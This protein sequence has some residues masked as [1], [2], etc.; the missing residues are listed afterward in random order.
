M[1]DDIFSLDQLS[2]MKFNICSRIDAYLEQAAEFLR[3]INAFNS[4]E[5][6]VPAPGSES[7]SAALVYLHHR[8]ADV[9]KE[10]SV[11]NEDL[12]RLEQIIQEKSLLTPPKRRIP[13]ASDEEF[14]TRVK[15]QYAYQR[16][17]TTLEIL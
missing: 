2:D 14:L 5:E 6:R 12:L 9:M 3:R 17:D 10:F 8:F 15:D 4:L 11:C 16:F 1:S 7:S 13:E